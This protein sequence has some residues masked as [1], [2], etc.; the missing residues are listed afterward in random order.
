MDRRICYAELEALANR[1]AAGFQK[2]GVGPG[3]H[4]GLYLPNTPHY[5]IAFFGVL[6]AGGTVVN[7]PARV[8]ARARIQDRGQRDRHP[9]HARSRLLYPQAEKLLATTRLNRLIVGEFAEWALAPDPVKAHMRA[10]GML[11]EPK[12][13]ERLLAFRDLIDNDGGFQTHPLGDLTDALAVIQYTGGTTGQPKG[14]MLTHANL[15]AACAQ[16]LET[17]H[18]GPNPLREGE[19]RT[20]CV[21]PLFHIYALSVLLVLGLRL[22]AEIVLHPRFD[23]PAAAERHRTQ[24]NHRLC[25]RADDAY[26]DAQFAGRPDRRIFR[27][28]NYARRAA[29]RCRM[30]FNR[31]SRSW[32]AAGWPRAGA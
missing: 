32:S 25:R 17:T 14:A 8:A 10:G 30:Q 7:I 9:R 15:S 28:S 23:P 24:E 27:R 1:A 11:S 18:V 29:R 4:V 3:V 13:G 26:R 22:G 12:Y 31:T 2:L 16:Y 5:P 21:L 19:E 6:K 20:L